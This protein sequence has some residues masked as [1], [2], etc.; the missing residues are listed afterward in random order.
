MKKVLLF[1]L[2]SVLTLG[3]AACGDDDSSNGSSDDNSGDKETLTVWSFTDELEP[4]IE[5]FK[6]EHDVDVELTI[7]P[8]ED[9]PTRLRPVLESGQ[10]APDIFTGELVFVKEWIEQGYWETLNQEPYNVEEISDDFV[11]YVYELGRNSSGE[12]KALSWQTTPGGIFY[13]RSIAEEVLGTDDPEAVGEMFATR[14]AMFETGAK[15]KDAGYRLF[16][17]EGAVRWFAQGQDPEPWVNENDELIMTEGRLNHFDYAKELREED[18]TAFAPEW[19][20]AWFAAMDGPINYN[21]GWDEVDAEAT[22]EVE[23]FSYAL[24]TWGLHSVLKPNV[25]DTAGD[26]AVTSGPN[27]YFWGG[28]WLGMYSGSENKDLAWEFIQMMTH[29]EEFLTD[30]ALETGD[31]LSYLPVTD[32]IKD[33]FSEDFLGGQNNYTFFLEEAQKIDASV[34][35]RYDQQIDTMFGSMVTEYVEGVKTKE[36]AVQEFYNLVRNSYPQITTPDQQ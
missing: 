26:W 14:D 15:L 16:P 17:D 21:A 19:S 10:G 2:I 8:I 27:P 28:T 12:V 11:E 13:R 6:E 34:V 1:L 9:Y 24:P 3:L 36:E 25:E 29:D 35:T 33:D 5:A 22:T 30:W 32:K 20:P 23:V 18:L 7:V 4:A 31:V